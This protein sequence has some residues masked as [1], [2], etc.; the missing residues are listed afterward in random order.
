M[1]C[2]AQNIC[3]CAWVGWFVISHHFRDHTKFKCSPIS[4]TVCWLHFLNTIKFFFKASKRPLYHQSEASNLSLLVSFAYWHDMAWHVLH[5][6]I[7]TRKHTRKLIHEKTGENKD[8]HI[9][10]SN[11][12]IRHF[13]DIMESITL[14]S[15]LI[16]TQYIRN[17]WLLDH[18]V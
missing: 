3:W 18:S 6:L 14:L 2:W 1:L 16:C 8:R 17:E 12:D 10:I 7:N 9:V 13:D 15:Y 11:L 4:C 5:I